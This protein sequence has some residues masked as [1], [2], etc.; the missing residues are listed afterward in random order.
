[1]INT[2]PLVSIYLPTYNRL[3]LLK[4]AVNSVLSQTYSRIEL[5]IVDDNSTD[6]TKEYLA[7]LQDPRIRVLQKQGLRG[8]PASRNL[9]IMHARGEYITGLDD[10]DFFHE[11]HIQLLVKAFDPKYSCVFVRKYNWQ[12][13]IFSPVCYFTKSVSFDQLK[14]FNIIGNQVFI[15]TQNIREIGGFSEVL[16]AA[17]DYELWLRITRKFGKAKML[18]ANT[19]LLDTAHE[20]TRITNDISAKKDAYE[21]IC[22][23]NRFDKGSFVYSS[24]RMRISCLG[25]EGGLK[26]LSVRVLINPLNLRA[27]LAC[28]KRRL[29]TFRK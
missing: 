11:S 14:Y 23:T 6:G 25:G 8:A 27:V 22:S 17:Q 10:D 29:L 15:K 12:D 9:A 2:M 19:Y 5:L 18:V 16:R 4:R 3:R 13:L 24:F 28:M 7:N 20:Y 1:M 26:A 21:Y